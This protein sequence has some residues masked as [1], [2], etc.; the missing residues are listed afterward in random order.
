MWRELGTALAV[1]LVIEGVIPFLA[2]ARWRNLTAAIATI[3]DQN[4]RMLGFASMIAGVL[5][6]YIVR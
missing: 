2:P 5:L 3:N 6:L 1:V 4:I